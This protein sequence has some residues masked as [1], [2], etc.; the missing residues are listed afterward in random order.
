[1][2]K[3]ATTWQLMKASWHVLMQDKALLVFPVVS[4]IA[5]FLV[6]R[7]VV[8]LKDAWV[9][10]N[11][12]REEFESMI[13]RSRRSGIPMRRANG[14]SPAF[15]YSTVPAGV[16]RDIV[17]PHGARVPTRWPSRRARAAT[18]HPPRCWNPFVRSAC[19][20]RTRDKRG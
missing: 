17:A 19:C 3:T 9:R 5:C 18:R 1:M 4:G 15:R 16:S 20:R 14:A 8:G 11:V 6:D 10:L 7:G 2:S 12:D 13:D